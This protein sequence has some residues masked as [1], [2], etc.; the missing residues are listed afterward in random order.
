M[1]KKLDLIIVFLSAIIITIFFHRK[2]LGINLLI[3]ETL[4]LIWF[5]VSKQFRFRT[6]NQVT[7]GF[8]LL[9]TSM[10]TVLTHSLFSYII[11][12]LALFI[13]IGILIY[14]GVKSILNSFGL[15]FANLFNSQIQFLKELTSVN[16]KGHQFGGFLWKSRIFIIPVLIIV[17][18][19]FIYRQSNP[20][21]DQLLA[22]VNAFIY[23]HVTVFFKDFDSFI[24]LTFVIGLILSSYFFLRTSDQGIIE[25]DL[26]SSDE[27]KRIKHKS[28]LDFKSIAL[29]NEYK[30]GVFLLIVLNSVL[31]ILNV[32]DIN[33]V[34]FNFEWEGQYLKQFVH[35]GTFLLIL[36][37]LISIALVLYFFRGNLNFYAN[38][39]LLKYL[40]YCWIIQN[41]ILTISVA[42]RNFYYINYFSLAYGRIGVIIFLVLTM[43]GL[44]TV[45]IKVG[46][47]KSAFYLFKSNSFAL[48]V[49][50]VFCSLINWDSLIANYNFK[51][52]DKSFLHLNYL[53]TLTDKSLP[54]LDKSLTELEQIDKIQKEKFPFEQKFMTPETYYQTIENRKIDF[55]KKW[56]SKKILSWNLPEYLAYKKITNKI[57]P[58]ASAP[59][60]R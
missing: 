55:I 20:I 50:L 30:A 11:N 35:E 23:E 56:E 33:W 49:V 42:I 37:I 58:V 9:I 17:F 2:A 1:K 25:S 52:A 3:F 16:I 7:C 38:N 29:R 14:P 15:S 60:K 51:H 44:Y 57:K 41:G 19:I 6:K 8:A 13:F 53:S 32:I 54:Y 45:L 47:C 24:I 26:S 48:F 40:S 27:L 36:S 59:N 34:W 5:I 4:L 39:N 12:F 22:N 46:Q 21:F 31:L 43:Y 10:F 18:F 28:L